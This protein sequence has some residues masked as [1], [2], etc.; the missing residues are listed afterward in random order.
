MPDDIAGAPRFILPCMVVHHVCRDRPIAID[1]R[2]TPFDIIQDT[3]LEH[4]ELL[5][6]YIPYTVK[7]LFG[8]SLLIFAFWTIL[9]FKIN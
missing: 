1:P 2:A 8:G 6:F 9:Y 7:E 3:S 5:E 4:N